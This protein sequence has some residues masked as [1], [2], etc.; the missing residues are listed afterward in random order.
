MVPVTA[1]C[2]HCKRPVAVETVF[3]KVPELHCGH[4][5]TRQRQ[6]IYPAAFRE[7]EAPEA[8][9]ALED[10]ASCYFHEA[11][12]AVDL[13]DDCG[14]Y[15][16]PLCTLAIPM[17]ASAPPD[18]PAQVCPSCFSNRV[19][20]EIREGQWDLFRTDYPRHDIQALFLI[21]VPVIIFPLMIFSLVTLPVAVYIV[22]RNWRTC[23]TPVKH[24]RKSMLAALVLALFGIMIWLS[25]IGMTAAEW[26]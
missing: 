19:D 4:C 20:S 22:L 9:P 24:F 5:G 25:L 10:G 18:F 12:G 17:P 14:R 7:A 3:E 15:L 6:I 21:I 13:C 23:H 2:H 8:V 26:L 1:E 11:A 16:C